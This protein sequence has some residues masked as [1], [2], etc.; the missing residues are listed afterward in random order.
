MSQNGTR[1]PPYLRSRGRFRRA[2][3]LLEPGRIFV[4]MSPAAGHQRLA[5]ERESK[6]AGV[7]Q[8]EAQTC[9]PQPQSSGMGSYRRQFEHRERRFKDAIGDRVFGGRGECRLL[10]RERGVMSGHLL[11]GV[12]E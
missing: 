8:C 4:K 5:P 6:D 10:E 2:Q 1:R 11:I 3:T 7:C 12:S 9:D